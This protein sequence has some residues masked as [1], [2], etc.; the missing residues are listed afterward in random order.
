MSLYDDASLIMIPSGVKTGK[1]YSQKPMDSDGQFTF[2]R[3]SEATRLVDGVVTKVRTNRA[4]YSE[5]FSYGG[6]SKLNVTAS[7]N[8]T[9]APDG[10]T[11]ADTLTLSSSVSYVYGGY[12]TFGVY[13]LSCYFK[14]GT[15]NFVALNVQG[16]ATHWVTAVFDLSTGALGEYAQGSGGNTAYISHTIASAGS[17]WYRCS[18]TINSSNISTANYYSIMFAPAATGN[19]FSSPYGE[20]SSNSAGNT[21]ISWGAQYEQGLVSTQYI[22][23]TTVAVSEGPVANM[24]RLNS[25]AGGCSSLKLEPQRTNLLAYSEYFGSSYWNQS[26]TTISSNATTSPDGYVNASKLVEDTSTGVHKI[27]ALYTF[28]AVDYSMSIRIKPNGITK[29][30]LWIDSASKGTKFDLSTGTIHSETSSVGKITALPNGWFEIATTADGTSGTSYN[31][32]L[33]DDSWNV[34]YTGDGTSGVYIYGA[35]LEAGSYATS[36]IPNY[37]TTAGVTR[38]ADTCSGAG[39]ASTFNDSEG[40]LYAEISALADDLTYR[41]LSISNGTT[42]ER[43]Y[44]Q[45]TSATNTVSVVIKNGSTTQ[46]N[47]GYA[48]SDETELAKVAIKYKANDFAL[49]VNGFEVGTDASGT[50]PTGLSVLSFTDGGGGGNN[51]YGNV[52]QLLTFNTALTDTELA[53][54]TTL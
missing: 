10:T 46:A 35:Q 43:I 8:T 12:S 7:T 37:G 16:S 28:T 49:W 41:I 22:A 47:M 13:T 54:L 50:T 17:G 51:F 31:V 32:Y 26:S 34:T 36:Y 30:S 42:A 48:L 2:T 27:Q 4:L 15:N 38:V 23:T 52:N 33:Y 40:V 53:T 29:V 1:V 3:A 14:A 24:P 20:A 45:Y 11:T 19:S 44:M 6:W 25:V 21:L 39:S 5:D 9:T 18:L